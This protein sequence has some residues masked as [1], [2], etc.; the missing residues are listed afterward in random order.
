[1]SRHDRELLGPLP[2]FLR[3]GSGDVVSVVT[4]A[5]DKM[6]LVREYALGRLVLTDKRF[7]RREAAEPHAPK[8]NDAQPAPDSMMS[9]DGAD[10]ARLRRVVAGAFAAGRVAA[11]SPSIQ[12][13][14]GRYLDAIATSGPGTD[15]IEGLAR[16]LP[17]AIICSLLGVPQEDGSQFRSWVDVLFDLSASSP[18]EKARRRLK[19]VT[20]MTNLIDHKR[21]RPEEDLLS[22]MLREHDRG[23][24]S[25]EEFV[26]MGLALL[27]AGYETTV[28]QIGLSVLSLLSDRAVWDELREWPDRL[29]PVV[30]ELL[31]LTPS[32]P[33]SFPRVAVEDVSLGGVTVHAGEAVIVSLLDANRD[34]EAFDEPEWLV[35]SRR[36]ASH[37]TFGHG[38][39]R[40]LGAPLARL[41]VHTVLDGLMHRFPSLRLASRPDAVMWK[42]GLVTRGLSQLL[43]EW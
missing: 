30:E 42:D 2:E 16:P 38:V 21:R 25:K 8:L 40:C 31:R 24:L 18:R 39:H 11:M 19:L 10:H 41:Q 14:T 33:V 13:L 12:R 6:W 15:V 34:G 4:P 23:L 37:L 9:M 32:T 22:D 28:G 20:Y 35:P 36:S 7:S 5:G 27:M 29:A 17:L 26:T 3:H 43:V 1:M